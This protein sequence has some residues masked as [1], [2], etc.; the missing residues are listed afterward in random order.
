MTDHRGTN[1][2]RTSFLIAALLTGFAILCAVAPASFRYFL[3][4][5]AAIFLF[6]LWLNP[7]HRYFRVGQAVVAVLFCP[8]LLTAAV[9]LKLPSLL[10]LDVTPES[11]GPA[12]YICGSALAIGCF[13][14][15]L[16][17]TSD[18]RI[19]LL[20]AKLQVFSSNRLAW[21]QQNIEH[22]H[23][24]GDP[25]ADHSEVDIAV[26]KTKAGMPDVAID[27]LTRL[28][29][30]TPGH[31]RRLQYRIHANLGFAHYER[32]EHKEAVVEFKKALRFENDTEN[33]AGLKALTTFLSDDLDTAHETAKSALQEFPMSELALGVLIQSAP[34]DRAPSDFS[35]VIPSPLSESVDILFA[36][37]RWAERCG[38]FEQACNFA[39]RAHAQM[40]DSPV[41]LEHLAVSLQNSQ[42]EIFRKSRI[43][44]G[45]PPNVA[46]LDESLSLYQ[47]LLDRSEHL[48]KAMLARVQHRMAVCEL[49]RGDEAAAERHFN[50]S[51][52]LEP[53]SP[54]ALRHYMQLLV[55]VD[56]KKDAQNVLRKLV[57]IDG[58]SHDRLMLAMLL[59]GNH[60]AADELE[61]F[62]ILKTDVDGV[63][64]EASNTSVDWLL[65]LCLTAFSTGNGN[66]FASESNRLAAL[67]KRPWLAKAFALYIR[68]AN[69]SSEDETPEDAADALREIVS[70]LS[71]VDTVVQ[72]QWLAQ[73]CSRLEQFA[74]ALEVWKPVAVAS[75]S[76]PYWHHVLECASRSK[77]DKFLLEF[78]AQ[79]RQRGCID[80]HCL[81]AELDTLGRYHEDAKAIE[82]ID[83]YLDNITDPELQAALRVRRSVFATRSGRL[84]L[85]ETDESR[86]PSATTADVQIGIWV[87]EILRRS[88]LRECA[89]KFAYTL[90][91]R[92]PNDAH[93][94][95][96]YVLAFNPGGADIRS[97]SD[98]VLR[99]DAVNYKEDDTGEEHWV[100]LEEDGNSL[101]NNELSPSHPL[102]IELIG[103]RQ[104][105]SMTI[106]AD[107]LQRRTGTVKQF[108]SKY[109]FRAKDLFDSWERRFPE[110]NFVR[111]FHAGKNP[112]GGADIQ[113]MLQMMQAMAANDELARQVF[114]S[115]PFGISTFA[116]TRSCSH[117][118]SGFII[119][120]DE[121]LWNRCATGL[122]E[123]HESSRDS[124]DDASIVVLDPSSAAT[125]FTTGIY[126]N[127]PKLPS[128]C[129][130]PQSTLLSLQ[131]EVERVSEGRIPSGYTCSINGR[132]RYIAHDEAAHREY[133]ERLRNYLDWLAGTCE[134]R[135]GASLA[136]IE[137]DVREQYEE[138]F[139]A[140]YAESAFLAKA[141]GAIHWTDD[142]T[143][144]LVVDRENAIPRV[145][146]QSYFDG[147]CRLGKITTEQNTHYA[148][149]LLRLGF[150]PTFW[151]SAIVV[152]A[153]KEADWKTDRRPLS[154][155]L[156]F[157]DIGD[158][159][160]VIS[161]S[162][163]I[164]IGIQLQLIVS[165]RMEDFIVAV[166]RRIAAR[167]DGS[168]VL[169]EIVRNLPI[170]FGINVTAAI[171]CNDLVLRAVETATQNGLILP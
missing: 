109:F 33:A 76:W 110:V 165:S 130:V 48:P 143:V 64:A 44:G 80:A 77:S 154:S 160:A 14:L 90:T 17:V 108:C 89:V 118:Q 120:N 138:L 97:N 30:R 112:D 153:G 24:Y 70:L 16:V 161:L 8:S 45:S 60:N 69:D 158:P 114:I 131:E 155:V 43:A 39:R 83:S 126:E 98:V 107:E 41:L 163:Q 51:L 87:V 2:V 20:T 10:S 150:E 34:L 134:V 157:F 13:I 35:D 133:R 123:E 92:F 102:A 68:I 169:A 22:Q 3:L 121:E 74:V 171:R 105:E 65:Q 11:P 139:G 81:H 86:L 170:A 91:K 72:R 129:L 42:V 104:G 124:L 156:K 29:Q 4:A 101:A 106:R 145:W 38:D 31:D 71:D 141:E 128:R 57:A 32:N 27:I 168:K 63:A 66:W 127:I 119:G 37:S 58:D 55:G 111:K 56:R 135:G 137:S 7:R 1:W 136:S 79:L 26:S 23:N 59:Y 73:L 103:K 125:L 99:G 88:G 78:C 50:A 12:F 151:N 54:E 84:D 146:T 162:I 21:N 113:P 53:K 149:Q 132:I 147:M 117:I 166:M 19:R 52:L 49:M 36:R 62:E 18:S 159:Q 96:L 5:F 122:R 47:T 75:P 116:R 85:V 25:R 15:D 142:M 46:V 28:M 95:Q 94:H 167:R 40:Q 93:L 140:A 9:H 115:N 61:A 82:T 144:A 100:I 6:A 164:C 148:V 67:A 152:A